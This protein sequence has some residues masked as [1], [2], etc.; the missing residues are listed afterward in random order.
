[1]PGQTVEDVMRAVD[2]APLIPW[3]LPNMTTRAGHI[4][5]DV[6][7]VTDILIPEYLLRYPGSARGRHQPVGLSRQLLRRDKLLVNNRAAI[8]LCGLP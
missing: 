3:M 1:M 5:H 2:A 7:C 4:R 8:L 6:H